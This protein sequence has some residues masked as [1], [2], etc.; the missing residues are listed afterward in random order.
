[1][2]DVVGV[3]E[4]QGKSLDL[5]YIEHWAKELGVEFLWNQVKKNLEIKDE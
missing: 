5:N 1:M 4:V 2:L 3:L